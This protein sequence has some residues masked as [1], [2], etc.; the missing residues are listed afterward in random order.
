MLFNL[1][2]LYNSSKQLLHYLTHLYGYNNFLID[3]VNDELVKSLRDAIVKEDRV[4][5]VQIYLRI[6][7]ELDEI[8]NRHSYKNPELPYGSNFR[9]LAKELYRELKIRHLINHDDMKHVAYILRFISTSDYYTTREMLV[10]RSLTMY[11]Y[12]DIP[13][14]PDSFYCKYIP[15]EAILDYCV[16]MVCLFIE[17]R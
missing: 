7:K 15:L 5:A 16:K 3:E 9:R 8:R 13:I 6:D 12:W 1:D 11:T 4:K 17:W 10:K 2:S 14:D